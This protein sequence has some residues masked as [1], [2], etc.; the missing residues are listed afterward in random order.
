M[1]D[2]IEKDGQW[3]CRKCGYQL[4]AMLGDD[5]IPEYCGC[6]QVTVLPVPPQQLLSHLDDWRKLAENLQDQN[7]RLL[8]SNEV[9]LEHMETLSQ[10]TKKLIDYDNELVSAA[11]DVIDYFWRQGPEEFRRERS[12]PVAEEIDKQ[13]M[14]RLIE[15]VDSH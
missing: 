9:M 2:F 10:L 14:L 5:E 4:S 7:T 8:E 15:L 13:L 12:I 11:K 3:T 1:S 6:D